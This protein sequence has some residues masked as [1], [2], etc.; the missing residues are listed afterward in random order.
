MINFFGWVIFW[1]VV[2]LFLPLYFLCVSVGFI[3]HIPYL[4]LKNGWNKILTLDTD[5]KGINITYSK[6]KS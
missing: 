5:C 1:V 2:V 4:G 3:V 6:K